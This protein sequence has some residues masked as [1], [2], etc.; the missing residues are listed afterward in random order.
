M[1]ASLASSYPSIADRIH[2]LAQPV[3]QWMMG[4]A[5][6]ARPPVQEKL[7]LLYPS[8]GYPHKN[9][10]LLCAI[11]PQDAASWPVERL[12]LTLPPQSNP[13]P[14]VPWIHCVGFLNPAQM[15]AAYQNAHAMV[16]LSTKESFGFPLLE[17]M[18][19]GLPIV[20]ADLPYAHALCAQG[21]IYFDPASVQSLKNAIAELQLR[22]Q[23]GWVPDWTAQLQ[24]FP[25]DW[26]RVASIMAKIVGT[27]K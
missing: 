11:G 15:I 12:E 8:A 22:L 10:Q 4:V 26:D 7:R 14:D 17:A 25:Q 23:Q 13:A 6:A 19:L 3:P 16:F 21:A 9:H 2:V 27:A 24:K 18:Y 5:R 1:R 20:C